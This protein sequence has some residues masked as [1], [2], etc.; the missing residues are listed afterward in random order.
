MANK[1]HNYEIGKEGTKERGRGKDGCGK[2][3]MKEGKDGAKYGRKEG[4]R[5]EERKKQRNRERKRLNTNVLATREKGI[6]VQ[7]VNREIR[8]SQRS[9]ALLHNG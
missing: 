6:R 1:I 2:K 3:G 7:G 9:C 8:G 5:K 4:K